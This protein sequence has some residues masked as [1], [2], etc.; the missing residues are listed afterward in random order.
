MTAKPPDQW[1]RQAQGSTA[2]PCNALDLSFWSE[3]VNIDGPGALDLNG[4]YL[5]VLNDHVLVLG[6]RGF[7]VVFVHMREFGCSFGHPLQCAIS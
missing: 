3:S 6:R 5:L 4:L 1:R 2:S 7:F